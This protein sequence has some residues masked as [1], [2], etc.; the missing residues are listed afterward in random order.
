VAAVLNRGD[1]VSLGHWSQ[2]Q[3]QYGVRGKAILG[4][5]RAKLK[6]LG[7]PTV[8]GQGML[9]LGWRI[10]CGDRLRFSSSSQLHTQELG[11]HSYFFAIPT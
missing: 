7:R 4:D 8:L 3:T 1:P 5:Q 10:M 9:K 11:S 6:G 2:Q